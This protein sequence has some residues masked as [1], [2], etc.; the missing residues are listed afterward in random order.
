MWRISSSEW[1]LDKY[2]PNIGVIA[3][4]RY[5]VEHTAAN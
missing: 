5:I 3:C 4:H 2:M 1:C